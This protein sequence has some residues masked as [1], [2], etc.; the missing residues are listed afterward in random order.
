[1]ILTGYLS[2]CQRDEWNCFLVLGIFVGVEGVSLGPSLGTVSRALRG[3]WADF[4]GGPN[5]FFQQVSSP[6]WG[7]LQTALA[8]GKGFEILPTTS[9]R[10]IQCQL[11]ERARWKRAFLFSAF[12]LSLQLSDQIKQSAAQLVANCLQFKSQ[13]IPTMLSVGI[14]VI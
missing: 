14:H 1:M 9:D 8:H 13:Q 4:G 5:H 6:I 3:L 2:F 7:W 12:S 11:T 10:S